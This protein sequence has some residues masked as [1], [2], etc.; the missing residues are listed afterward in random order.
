MSMP[1]V[2][3]ALTHLSTTK[4]SAHG[5]AWVCEAPY[6]GRME[7][8][9]KNHLKAWREFRQMSQEEL[10]DKVDTAK[11]VISLLENNKR[12]L[13]DKWLYRLASALDT[14]AGFI[15]DFDPNDLDTRMLEAWANVPKS[16]QA[17][18]IR[19]VQ[20]FGKTGTEDS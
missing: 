16:D 1:L 7:K 11:G 15:L 10:A 14:R 12:P 17:Q 5:N 8:P 6:N 20:T 19:V 3:G 2:S 13:S 4:V 18:A 9:P